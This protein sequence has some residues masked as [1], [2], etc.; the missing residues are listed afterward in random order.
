MRLYAIADLHI[1][2]KLNRESLD[3][4][5][6]HPEDGLIICGDIG[7]SAEHLEAAFKKACDCFKHV[8]WV[9]G[10]HELYTMPGKPEQDR[11]EAKYTM[12]VEI[13]RQFGI[14]TPE[15]P[16]MLWEGEGGPCIIAPIF[17]LYDYSFR[18][19]DVSREGALQWA[20]E[21]GIVA[22]D[23]HLLHPDPFETR[24]EWC[25]DL[26]ISTEKKLLKAAAE[27]VPLILINHWPLREDLVYIPAIPRFSLWCGTKKTTDWHK[28]YNAKV[29]VS[30]HLHV[31][32]TDW[33]DG[34]RF[35]EC[36]LGYPKQWQD[37][38]ERGHNINTML[39]E[40]LPGPPTPEPGASKTIY[41]R[42]G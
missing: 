23:E 37:A 27:G 18:P 7:E 4:L 29:V 17:T 34:V 38:R 15:D 31:R 28:K 14:L 32:R 41:R 5:D 6:Q 26:V 24:D 33:I 12:C 39:R 42:Y 10:N 3:E 19:E 16:Y 8:F 20:E 11:G 36:S 40:I 21:K 1:G 13:A 9:P 30:G 2:H 35:E 22:T 25:E